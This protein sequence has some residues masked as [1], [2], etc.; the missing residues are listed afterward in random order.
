MNMQIF[1]NIKII[2]IVTVKGFVTFKI[3]FTKYDNGIHV[4]RQQEKYELQIFSQLDLILKHQLPSFGEY[5]DKELS[6]RAGLENKLKTEKQNVNFLMSLL[7]RVLA[8]VCFYYKKTEK[9]KIVR[10]KWLSMHYQQ[11]E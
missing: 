6:K 9:R 4:S 11:R 3:C 10:V 7:K 2:R 8:Q 1:P 5:R